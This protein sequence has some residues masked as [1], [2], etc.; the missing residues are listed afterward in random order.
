L[1]GESM[2]GKFGYVR[3]SSLDQ[4]AERQLEGIQVDRV[5]FDQSSGKDVNRPGLNALLDFVRDGDTIIVHSMDRLARN[6]EHLRTLVLNLT[7]RGIRI[8][9]IKENLIFTEEDDPIATLMLSIMGSFAEFERSLIKERQLEGIALAKRRGAYKGRIKT[10][11]GK[12]ISELK[13]RY[14]NG[15]QKSQ[16]AREYGVSR[17][18]IYNYLQRD[19]P[20][21][22]KKSTLLQQS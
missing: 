15:E 22:A 4:K 12:H 11:N 3:V 10:L 20:K 1:F 7:K 9:F 21:S 5:F 13:K 16:L 18:T 14:I 19:T 17:Q 8:H 2:K 6:L